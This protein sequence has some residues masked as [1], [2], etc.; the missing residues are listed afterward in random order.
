MLFNKDQ[1][2][3]LRGVQTPFYYYDLN[4]LDATLES[5]KSAADKRGFHVHYALKAN[6]N[7]RLLERIQAKGFGA[8]CVSGNE[9]QK[10]VDTGFPADKITFAGV[11][12]S[13][14]EIKTALRH[15]IFAFNVESIQE[16]EVID[17]LAGELGVRANVSLRIN[18]NVDANTHHYIT[19]GLDENKFGVPTSELERAASVI[20]DSKNVDLIGLHFHVGSQITDLNV[21]KSL[22][23]KVNEWKSWFEER[24]TLIRVLNVG[25][26]LGVDYLH[27][28]E[29]AIPDFEAYFDIFDRFLER[30]P[31]QEVH[32][33]LGRALVAQSGSLISK[34]LY[35]KSGVK[36]HFLILDAGMTELMRPAL[37]Q[38]YHKIERVT[39]SDN[40]IINYDVVGPICE[41][42]DCFGKEVP[43]P[44]SARGD[45][46]AVRTAGAYGE[47][48]ASRYN[49]RNEIRY[50]YSDSL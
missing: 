6:F 30:G 17:E 41:S 26:G 33:E 29:H 19:T 23:V 28:D 3:K 25:G 8:D 34:V 10:A 49:L 15:G 43:L 2:D 4:L 40:K 22:C 9:V 42:S 13:D 12:K 11:G 14:V 18:P 36:K 38:A 46:I 44:E 24:G 27:P 48:M 21:F 39:Q 50:I 20:R 45:L 37:Y 47:V 35:T 1:Q 32:F 31:Q 16:M 7:D 5:A